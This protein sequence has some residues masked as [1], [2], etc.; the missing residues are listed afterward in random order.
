V[1]DQQ[2]DK[3]YGEVYKIKSKQILRSLD[4]YEER[5]QQYPEPHEY[6]R[7]KRLIS[8]ANAPSVIAWVYLFNQD[9]QNLTRI[10]SG[11]YLKFIK[12]A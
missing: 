10:K 3:V 11:Y 4:A 12:Q 9:V 7:T 2:I 5:T 1:S 8:F 6:L